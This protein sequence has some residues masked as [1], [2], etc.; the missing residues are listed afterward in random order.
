M[1]VLI[2][3]DYPYYHGGVSRVLNLAKELKKDFEVYLVGAAFDERLPF[4]RYKVRE[5]VVDGI[6]VKHFYANHLL[7]FLLFQLIFLRKFL[8]ANPVDILQAY[9]P[10]YLTCVSSMILKITGELK[11]VMMYDDIVTQRDKLGFLHH[12]VLLFIEKSVCKLA[13]KI[14]VLTSYQKDYLLGR[15]IPEVKLS[16][17]PNLVD[18]DSIS[19]SV[20]GAEMIRRRL[21]IDKRIVLGYVGSVNRR[22]GLE[23][24]VKVM[25]LLRGEG[26]H[27]L[28]VGGG[29]ALD[30]LKSLV[31]EMGVQSMVTFTGRV[32]HEEVGGYYSAIDI[33]ICPFTDSPASLAVDHMKVYEY[34]ATGK[35]T[36]AAGVGSVLK[37]IKD[38]ENGILYTSGE[39]EELSEKILYLVSHPGRS[40]KIASKGKEW[41][42]KKHDVKVIGELWKELY[43][44]VMGNLTPQTFEKEYTSL[45]LPVEVDKALELIGYYVNSGEKTLV[46]ADDKVLLFELLNRSFK[47]THVLT[48]REK[49]FQD[50]KESFSFKA[51]LWDGIQ[52]I[53]TAIVVLKEPRMDALKKLEGVMRSAG[54][55]LIF[56]P[57]FI[58]Y[59]LPESRYKLP[60][61][62]LTDLVFPF[63]VTGWLRDKGYSAEIYG[64]RTI[65]SVFLG[66][67]VWFLNLVGK[68]YWADRVYFRNFVQSLN[69][70]SWLKYMSTLI[71]VVG[72][73]ND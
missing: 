66:R 64:F 20:K 8:R 47:E 48:R 26:F 5:E 42:K 67:L 32:P 65:K 58:R 37:V 19:S 33:L 39:V 63:S 9:N 52:K 41:V 15:E 16:I 70:D 24:M 68:E 43:S 4:W 7:P 3:F 12:R 61:F 54:V 14:A 57:M 29:D 46:C 56:S 44:G 72:R 53:D 6:K 31:S 49:F 38:E 27:L 28:V 51:E 55:I 25:P 30:E 13:D 23:D 40:S 60:I 45:Y 18:V 71:V 17:I 36:I 35:P 73:R 11:L 1:R 34:L 59:R 21:G 22:V 69:T 2:L 50:L 10:T 62:F